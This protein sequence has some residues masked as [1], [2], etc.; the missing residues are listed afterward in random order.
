MINSKMKTKVQPVH[1]E[2]DPVAGKTA[3]S[4]YLFHLNTLISLVSSRQDNAQNNQS[5]AE[6]E[7]RTFILLKK[8]LPSN[9][10]LFV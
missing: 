10:L 4:I 7:E 6:T 2:N 5:G 1:A 8:I 3:Y 9:E